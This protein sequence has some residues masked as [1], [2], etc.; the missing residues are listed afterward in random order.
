MHYIKELGFGTIIKN[1]W[2][3]RTLIN[4]RHL[5]PN[6]EHVL[7]HDDKILIKTREVQFFENAKIDLEKSN[8][9][10]DD[11]IYADKIINVSDG[12]F[13]K[14]RIIKYRNE[15]DILKLLDHENIIKVVD[16]YA[17][18]EN[19]FKRLKWTEKLNYLEN[20]ATDLG[21]LHA[22]GFVHKGLHAGNI[23]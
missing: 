3:K 9:C 4:N 15:I 22:K 13:D 11:S 14:N 12:K 10:Y 18:E 20:I 8:N 5:E 17:D 23:L 7:N 1:G 16:D 19:N 2:N 21:I 6:Q